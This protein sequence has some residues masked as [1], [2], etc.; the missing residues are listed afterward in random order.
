MFSENMD[1]TIRKQLQALVDRVDGLTQ[2]FVTDRD[3][4]PISAIGVAG[5]WCV[6]ALVSI[7]RSGADTCIRPQLLT[8]Y[9]QALEHTRKLIY[10]QQRSMVCQY[11]KYQMVFFNCTPLCVTVI[12]TAAANTG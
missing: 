10:G 6:R 3:G 2:L 9:P 11:G 7:W 4:V 8:A 1:A 12:A 5:A